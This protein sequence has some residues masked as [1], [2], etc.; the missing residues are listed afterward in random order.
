MTI[1][2]AVKIIIRTDYSPETTL[3]PAKLEFTNGGKLVLTTTSSSVVLE[4]NTGGE[5]PD[6]M[7]DGTSNGNSNTIIVGSGWRHILD[8]RHGTGR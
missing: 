4:N 7:I 1:T 2:A 3:S 5:N 8:D 6:P